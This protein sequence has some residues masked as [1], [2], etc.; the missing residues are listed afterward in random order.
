[1]L[2]VI[3]TFAILGREREIR[4]NTKNAKIIKGEEEREREK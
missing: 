4:V 1:M 3:C 2:I